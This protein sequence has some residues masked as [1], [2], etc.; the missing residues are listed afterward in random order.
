MKKNIFKMKMGLHGKIVLGAFVLSIAASS[1]D[2]DLDVD[3]QNAINEN[4]F[5]NNPDNAV[6]LVN[7]VY[8]KMLDF[9]MYSFS[10][11]GITSITSDDA[12]KGSSPGDT[13]TD[14]HKMDALTF[15]ASDLSFNEVWKGRYAGIYRANNALFYLEQLQVDEALKNRL[16]GEVK[17]LRA[18]FYFDLVRCFGDV[19]LVVGKIDLNDTE[20]INQTVFVRRPKAE[21]YDQIE[22]DLADAIVKLPLKS[23]YAARDLGR[24]SKGAA[25][26]LL[27][28]AHLYQQEWDAAFNMAG[29]VIGSGQYG[30]MDNYA[31]V[32]RETG[33]NGEES[34]FEVQATLTKGLIQYTGVQ[35]PRG[36]PD[37][38]WG[39]NT[40]SLN[41]SNSYETGDPRRAATIMDVPG[42]LW[43]GFVAPATWANPRYNYKA[44]QS[45]IAESWNNNKDETAKNL[46]ILKYSDI[47]LIRAEAAFRMG[48]TTEARD[49][50][51]EIR[52]RVGL[53]ELASVTLQQIYNERRWEMAMEH[54]RWFDLVRTGQA[55]AAMAADG[56]TFI[57]GKHEV[58][59]IP[60]AQIALSGGIL[61]QNNY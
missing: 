38:G 32:W 9:D 43:D 29:E 21:V 24:A 51:N 13:G 36:T 5:L 1:C 60:E 40:P 14:K 59:P 42:V 33:E 19:P 49:R 12:D 35:G 22:A 30:L 44:Y 57:V 48:N 4:D 52:G 50:V 20:L 61:T 58:F 41:L 47:L 56:K 6:Q 17:F 34:I 2:G 27:A 7:G 23:Q 8:N 37:L 25:Q 11:I 45:S 55:Q 10:W 18:L 16:I 3:P 39:F 26:A 15:D 54:D 46:R 53:G 31:E 28:K